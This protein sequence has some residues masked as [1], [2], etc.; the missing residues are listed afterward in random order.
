MRWTYFTVVGLALLSAGSI[1]WPLW[2]MHAAGPVPL[3]WAMFAIFV[4]GVGG[5]PALL[6][7]LIEDVASLGKRP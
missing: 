2:A 3:G 6:L 5:V 4:L 1:A 7:W